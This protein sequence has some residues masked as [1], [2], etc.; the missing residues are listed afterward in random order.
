VSAADAAFVYDK[1]SGLTC[2]HCGTPRDAQTILSGMQRCPVCGRTFQAV[3]FDPPQPDARV[4]RVAEAGPG[5][6]HAC[7]QHAGNA[8]VGHCSRCGVFLCGL[9]RIE[10]DG[11]VFC[12]ACFERLCDE[13]GLPGLIAGYRDYARVSASLALV[14]LLL[15][16][17][18][19][20]AGP[21]AIH[22]GVK[23]LAQRQDVN[24]PDGRSA[25]YVVC[26]LGGLEAFAAVALALWWVLK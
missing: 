19:P 14:G 16:F 9:C 4:A 6:A 3:R 2:P 1:Y 26:A 15:P 18:A 11:R 10:A 21:A 22:Y 5:G 13:G 24:R 12:P 7:P 23:A 20:L 25:I 17:L 8:S